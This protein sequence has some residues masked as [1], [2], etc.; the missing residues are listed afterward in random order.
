MAHQHGVEN[1]VAVLGT[2]LGERHI[3]VLRRFADSI[4]LVLDGDEAGRRRANE[5]LE[6]FVAN[7]VDLRILTLPESLDPCDLIA[8][9]GGDAFRRLLSGAV[10]ALEHKLRMVTNGLDFTRDTHRAAEAV[11][12]LLST[13]SRIRPGHGVAPSAVLLRE[14]QMLSVVARQFHLPSEQI[15]ARL[16]ALRRKATHAAQSALRRQDAGSREPP[17]RPPAD[18]EPWE[19]E[20]IELILIHSSLLAT[21]TPNIDPAALPTPLARAIY[22]RAIDQWERGQTNLFDRL[23]LESEDEAEK[24][25]L[26]TL[27]EHARE[28][29]A[30]DVDLRVA[31]LLAAHERRLAA[32]S[33]HQKLGAVQENDAEA[34]DLLAQFLNSNRPKHQAEFERRLN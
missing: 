17:V 24:H 12:Q 31:D 23:M 2:A 32:D 26:V 9:Q 15:R 6:L 30:S 20:L 22:T 21:I 29:S 11:E 5:I 18:W 33:V 28:K 13:L 34:D 10:D 27:D 4:V 19:R 1:V 3:P 7:Q 16:S 14:E 8:T 25:V